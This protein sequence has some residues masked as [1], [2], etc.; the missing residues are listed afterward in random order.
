[1]KLIFMSFIGGLVFIAANKARRSQVAPRAKFRK[2][3]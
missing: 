1:V 2:K 3:K